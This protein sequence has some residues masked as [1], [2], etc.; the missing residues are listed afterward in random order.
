[1]SAIEDGAMQNIGA[2]ERDGSREYIPLPGGWEI[3]T[4]GTGS[5]YR[6]LDKKS[7]ERHNILS[8]D[9]PFIYDFVTRMAKEVHETAVDQSAEL[10]RLRD[11]NAE[12][13]DSRKRNASN[14]ENCWKSLCERNREIEKA[15]ARIASLEAQVEAFRQAAFNVNESSKVTAPTDVLKVLVSFSSF[16]E[17]TSALRN[18][19]N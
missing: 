6:L 9:A 8:A 2:I 3:Q 19:E 12:L 5:S 11:R 14:F 10:T 7:D 1:M 13:E 18:T 17:L 4:K 15:N 16:Q